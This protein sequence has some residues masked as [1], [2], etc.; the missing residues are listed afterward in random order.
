MRLVSLVLALCC[1]AGCLDPSPKQ[2]SAGAAEQTT[3][4]ALQVILIPADGGTEDGTRA[5]FQPLF[6]AI[7]KNSSIKFNIRVA[8]SYNAVV[9]ALCSGSADVAF[10]GPAIYL[11]AQK[12]GCADLLAVGVEHGKS[13]YF[14]G[15]FARAN[16]GPKALSDLKGKSVAFGDVNS[17]SSFIVPVAMLLNA[18]LDPLKD[19]D[20]VRI[21]GSHANAISALT[22][23]Q[24]DAAALSL[25]SFDKAVNQGSVNSSDIALI[26]TSVA[27]PNPPIVM[28]ATLSPNVKAD[29]KAAFKSVASV[30]GVRAESLVGY[31]GKP[32]ERY[33]TEFPPEKFASIQAMMDQVT[34]ELTAG[35]LDKAAKR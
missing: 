21:V 31:G 32:V 1:L 11:Q 15:I 2:S 22:H 8:Q 13:E 7:S 35:L 5:D 24:V 16:G 33:D 29:L 23:G 34:P 25:V 6:D 9:E 27:L 19:I 26:A 3:G 10:V 4:Q 18:K 20:R 28:R 12:R 14:A 17:A 30:S